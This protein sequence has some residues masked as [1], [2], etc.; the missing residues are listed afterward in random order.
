M[1]RLAT[2]CG[3][4]AVMTL[5]GYVRTK[6][7]VLEALANPRYRSW[8][9]VDARFPVSN[10]AGGAL[11]SVRLPQVPECS[12]MWRR[13]A[14]DGIEAYRGAESLFEHFAA[15]AESKA[16]SVERSTPGVGHDGSGQR[17]VGSTVRTE[18][19]FRACD[20]AH[21]EFPQVIMWRGHWSRP[22][23][24]ELHSGARSPHA[25]SNGS[26]ESARRLDDD[27]KA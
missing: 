19:N 8:K 6:D 3:R 23:P 11:T 17:E 5:Y 26:A 7:D 9:T 16:V 14:L 1:R 13:N 4:R 27:S 18:A 10:M 25:G 20:T 24:S 2:E 22:I 15:D 12:Y 21:D